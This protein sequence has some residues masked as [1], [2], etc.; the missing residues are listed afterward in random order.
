MFCP[1]KD[2]STGELGAGVLEVG[3]ILEHPEAS[4][5]TRRH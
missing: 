3:K 2:E 4:L 1:F 5:L